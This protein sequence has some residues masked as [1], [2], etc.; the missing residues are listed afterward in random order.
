MNQK[1]NKCK[2]ETE[3]FN[4]VSGWGTKFNSEGICEHCSNRQAK[5]LETLK[6]FAATQKE[7]KMQ[8]Q[9]EEQASGIPKVR[10]QRSDKGK[11]RGPHQGWMGLTLEQRT[12][13]IKAMQEGRQYAKKAKQDETIN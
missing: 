4:A 7:Q 6:Q 13:R 5:N 9:S 8:R 3:A 1:C 12:V 2:I 11:K 10:K